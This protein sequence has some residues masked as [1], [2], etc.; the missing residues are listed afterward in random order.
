MWNFCH[1]DIKAIESNFRH[2]SHRPTQS[3]PTQFKAWQKCWKWLFQSWMKWQRTKKQQLRINVY[4]DRVK[5]NGIANIRLLP[6]KCVALHNFQSGTFS[7][8]VLFHSSGVHVILSV[9]YYKIP[10]EIVH[11]ALAHIFKSG[12]R[13]THTQW[14]WCICMTLTVSKMKL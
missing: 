6:R 10:S 11:Y 9:S 12:F 5:A 2:Q 8:I 1:S 4:F 7:A 13:H 14:E 3:T